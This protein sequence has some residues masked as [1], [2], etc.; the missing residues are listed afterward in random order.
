MIPR[1]INIEDSLEKN[2]V[3]IIYGPRQVGKTTLVNDFLSRTC[4][5][6]K[7]FSGD[8]LDFANNFGKCD[9]ELIR[10]LL[11]D[12]Q[13]LVIDEAQKIEHIGTAIKLVVDHIQGIYVIAT[14][15]SSF[16][17]ANATDEP[18]TGRKNLVTLYPIAILELCQIQTQYELEK[19]LGEYLIYGTYPNVITYKTSEQKQNRII[20]IKDGYLVRDVL[21]FHNVKKSK[22]I[23]NLL[24]LLAFQLGSEVSTSELGSS[25]G[26][27]HKTVMRY[28]ELLEKSFVIFRLSGF[29]RNLRKEV[30]KM[31]KYYFYDLGIRN[32]LISNFNDLDTRDDIGQLWENFLMIER[33]KRNSYKKISTNYYFWR[34]YD[35]KEIDLIE[36][37]SGKLYGYEFKWNK[38]KVKPPEAWLKTYKNASYEVI[39]MKNYFEFIT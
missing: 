13:L 20:E 25:L 3:V 29:S 15:S 21:K 22:V 19:N 4:L 10:K 7:L 27:D 2:K 17:L 6:Y 37:R 9:L 36:E 39:T 18:L 34:T 31:D 28:L 8:Q 26:L 30:T 23:M 24:K 11:G 35:Q 12:T 38:D 1:A 14:G 16:D 5:K 33:M 32:A